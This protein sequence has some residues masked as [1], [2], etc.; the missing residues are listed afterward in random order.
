MGVNGIYGLSGSG[1][2]VESM[3][4]VGML[5]KQAEYDKMQQKYTQNE[6]KKTE[7]LDL[8]G[9]VQTFN[10]STLSQYKMSGNM[11]AREATSN[12]TSAV[13]ATA[14]SNAVTM[15]HY[16]EVGQLASAAYL[17]GANHLKSE[18]QTSIKL[19]DS[20]YSSLEYNAESGKIDVVDK[21]TGGD[22]VGMVASATALSFSISDGTTDDAV[23]SNEV[24]STNNLYFEVISDYPRPAGKIDT[25]TLIIETLAEEPK[26]E[27]NG[28]SGMTSQ[29]SVSSWF[30]AAA[31]SA[32]TT[33]TSLTF[34]STTYE[35][36][37][38]H[39][40][41][42]IAN[43]S[44]NDTALSFTVTNATEGAKNIEFSYA[45]LKSNISF[46]TM[47]Q[48]KLK[49]EF[50]TYTDSLGATQPKVTIKVSDDGKI[51][52]SDYRTGDANSL[53]LNINANNFNI[54]NS[55]Y[56]LESYPD[57]MKSN[58]MTGLDETTTNAEFFSYAFSARSNATSDDYENLISTVV[59]AKET[60]GNLSDVAFKFGIK[61]DTGNTYA[62][63]AFTYE[64]LK[65]DQNS[66]KFLNTLQTKM[67][68]A[69]LNLNAS[70]SDNRLVISSPTDTGGTDT[71]ISFQI[72]DSDETFALGR[73]DALATA[74]ADL[75]TTGFTNNVQGTSKIGDL[76]GQVLGIGKDSFND[77]M[78]Y[79]TDK[80]GY[81]SD[82]TAFSFKL[83]DG[84]N[85]ATVNVSYGFLSATNTSTVEGFIGLINDA[86]EDASSNMEGVT[87][88]PGT[89][90]NFKFTNNVTGATSTVKFSI[91]SNI[92]LGSKAIGK[93]S[94]ELDT[95]AGT[96]LDTEINSLFKS[97]FGGDDNYYGAM[98]ALYEQTKDG[99]D[100][101]KVA[102]SLT[103]ED[104]GSGNAATVVDFT[105]YDLTEL[106]GRGSNGKTLFGLL[107]E[108]LENTTIKVERNT[109]SSLKFTSK[110]LGTQ[111]KL[112]ANV[113]FGADTAYKIGTTPADVLTQAAG[114]NANTT[115]KDWF[116][117]I[118]NGV[119]NSAHFAAYVDNFS[120]SSMAD[121]TAFTVKFYDKVSGASRDI[122]FTYANL[123]SG[124][125]L[126]G[127]LNGNLGDITVTTEGG[128]LKF[129]NSQTGDDAKL[130]YEVVFDPTWGTDTYALGSKEVVSVGN[131]F[132]ASSVSDAWDNPLF[133]TTATAATGTLAG[134]SG[135]LYQY[136]KDDGSTEKTITSAADINNTRAAKMVNE[137]DENNNL[138][139][140]YADAQYGN[141]TSSEITT[142]QVYRHNAAQVYSHTDV[143]EHEA[144]Q[145][146][147]HTDTAATYSHSVSAEYSHTEYDSVTNQ[148]V[149]YVNGNS[150]GGTSNGN[151]GY[152]SGSNWVTTGTDSDATYTDTNS[153]GGNLATAAVTH[154]DTDP[155]EG[156]IV[157][158]SYAYRAV[159]ADEGVYTVIS[160]ST[161]QNNQKYDGDGNEG[162]AYHT[163]TDVTA[164]AGTI[165]DGQ[166]AYLD[167]S[168]NWVV[169]NSSTYTDTT[170]AHH[171]VDGTP[172]GEVA[173]DWNGTT[174]VTTS[175]TKGD[176]NQVQDKDGS[177]N[178]IWT[179]TDAGNNITFTSTQ[180]SI[181]TTA[182][183]IEGPNSDLT[184]TP[185]SQTEYLLRESEN[186][187]AFS[188]TLTDGTEGG[189]SQV[190]NVTYGMLLDPT[191]FSQI[192][193]LISAAA[194]EVTNLEFDESTNEL[195]NKVVGGN[196]NKVNVI[197]EGFT[198]G[199]P[200]GYGL[201]AAGLGKITQKLFGQAIQA[202]GTFNIATNNQT[203]LDKSSLK[204]AIETFWNASSIPAD[205]IGSG[206]ED[207][208]SVYLGKLQTALGIDSSSG[209]NQASAN[210]PYSI[211][212]DEIA[213]NIASFFTGGSYDT[214]GSTPKTYSKGNTGTSG[215]DQDRMASSLAYFLAGADTSHLDTTSVAGTYTYTADGGYDGPNN[216]A[217]AESIAKSFGIGTGDYVKSSY[218]YEISDEGNNAKFKIDDGEWI[219]DNATNSYRVEEEKLSYE[220]KHVSA[221]NANGEYVGVSTQYTQTPKT[222]TVT[223]QDLLDGYTYTDLA[224]AINSL[225]TNVRATYDSVQDRFSIY[226]RK[227][228]SENEI[229]LTVNDTN[230]VNFFQN[231]QL[232]Q[233]ENGTLI[234]PADNDTDLSK[235]FP[236]FTT[237][238][239]T[240][241]L[242]GKNAIAKIDGID[243]TNLENNSV[244]VNGVNYTFTERTHELNEAGTAVDSSSALTGKSSVA[245]SIT[246][247]SS[248]IMENVKSF[249]EK[250]NTILAKLYEW[251]D[252]KPNSDYK[253]LTAS[254]KESMKDEQIEKWEEKAKAGMLYHDRT[255]GNLIT[256]IRKSI[257]E[258]VDGIT[259]KYNNIFALGIS[260]TGLKGQLTI[261]EDKLQEALAADPDA[262]YN[263]FAKLDGGQTYYRLT[264][265]TTEIW[266]TELPNDELGIRTGYTVVTD[267]KTGEMVTKKVERSSYNGIAQRLGDILTKGMK[268]IKSVSGSSAE[269]SDDSELN[270]LMRELQTKMS[271]FQRMMKAFETQ[272]YK[273]YDAMESSLALLG[274]QLNYVTGAFQ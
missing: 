245:V 221:T 131:I 89:G 9:E 30:F 272:L 241:V 273:K 97:I 45:E 95:K 162:T 260:T 74:P 203:S 146:Y 124:D 108:K 48:N 6:W 29:T 219:T 185:T 130:S 56:K 209:Y 43:F 65:E 63:I 39:M 118:T 218:V 166:Y 176:V 36:Y 244:T 55:T 184:T 153:E 67:T 40:E 253:P 129:T 198:S 20:F 135:A 107:E 1:L 66:P 165:V 167:D 28:T 164:T 237:I 217:L 11:A 71:K 23:K 197:I 261:N 138:I 53:T 174:R 214:T 133:G 12:D 259:G 206:S 16:V 5:S 149:T 122:D 232:R 79:L 204:T 96:N 240:S 26:F 90:G 220:L 92:D 61:E 58:S 88:T 201:T 35:K 60:A 120:S 145:V 84:A 231:M 215:A 94:G 125:S 210:S 193:S 262:V 83:S 225:G 91:N 249:V 127:K 114:I 33:G 161:Y 113:N 189:K 234:D 111:L 17:I 246:Q 207:N 86:L 64:D 75:T 132:N 76:L 170:Q 258:N 200:D 104:V 105:Y 78:P 41:A 46:Q 34:N 116:S 112:S 3:V 150:E 49:S 243:Y 73:T 154:T 57:N 119:D 54:G 136:S 173:Y 257:S 248:K 31:K 68:A 85:E 160:T 156:T 251:Y 213:Q 247:D 250:Y 171:A 194:G 137:K 50:G 44:R 158:G 226:N 69:G 235:W 52:L 191:K 82:D 7:L 4:K 37:L 169:I 151:Y 22:A 182:L 10:N 242:T 117:T 103:F 268:N 228:G 180:T 115:I 256:D 128:K 59:A 270:N 205:N 211:T 13:T 196:S 172:T 24:V 254:Q 267:P 18:G 168:N 147:I 87:L 98:K 110:T 21:T 190:K 141:F 148:M 163:F 181:S 266:S 62:E 175:L 233:S 139:Y 70:I 134:G 195:S 222:V 239:A 263:V 142:S 126:F 152:Y 255:L 72:I 2:D 144:S 159:G 216:Q 81:D 227:S 179:Y 192:K 157:E 19:A 109:D 106:E 100:S 183:Y 252:E 38:K 264:N 187:I 265:G 51:L 42:S 155:T 121:T 238:G 93:P 102:F 99:A 236:N 230:A 212:S 80:Y 15:T 208:S 143:Y 229:R 101:A 269:L 274:A 27:L 224:V 178:P 140:K 188:F 77:Y 14:N 202:E 25:H 8:Y 32:T 223:Y 177:G 186:N 199:G 271:N 47:F 123:V